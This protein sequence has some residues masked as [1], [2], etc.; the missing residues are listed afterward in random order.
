[1]P[2]KLP[3]G[4]LTIV[5]A[6]QRLGLNY[7]TVIALVRRGALRGGRHGP[8][9]VWFVEAGSVDVLL[10]RRARAALESL[11]TTEGAAPCPSPASP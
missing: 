4:C 11:T 8:R 1:M 6:T 10:S 9:R 5:A 7:R 3:P 2:V